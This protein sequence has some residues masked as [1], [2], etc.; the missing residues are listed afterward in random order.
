MNDT[1]LRSR[2]LLALATCLA[3]CAAGPQVQ[4]EAPPLPVTTLRVEVRLTQHQIE[5][6]RTNSTVGAAAGVQMAGSPQVAAGGFAA[7]AAAGLIGSLI[8]VAIDAHRGSVA[9]HAAA[10]MREHAREVGI[11]ALIA[12]A[13]DGLDRHRFAET[14]DVVHVD[15]SEADDEKQG[16]FE[17]GT[18]VLVLVPSYAVNYDGD[19]FTYMLDARLVDR[20]RGKRGRVET[21][22]RYH[23]TFSYVVTA[24]ELG[25]PFAELTAERWSALF[26]AAAA[27]TVEMLGYD[28][29]ARPSDAQPRRSYRAL[30][31]VLDQER[32]ERSWVRS[33]A[34]LLSV[35][36]ASLDAPRK[37]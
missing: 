1:K 27:E 16:R 25:T 19:T 4:R 32:G 21:K 26:K 13:V 7:G 20:T 2:A 12:T 5:V 18:N 33:H 29:S 22:T 30:P 14:V 24:S 6:S 8:D 9:E 36:S 11:D 35:S 34:A 3:A 23:E 37:S 17:P 31:V 15:R 10:P 28:V